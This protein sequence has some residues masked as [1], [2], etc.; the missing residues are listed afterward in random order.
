MRTVHTTEYRAFLGKL[1]AAREQRGL[2]QRDVAAAL[3]IPQSQVSR[4]ES[5]ERSVNAVDGAYQLQ[6]VNGAPLPYT[7]NLGF[8][9]TSGLLVLSPK[10]DWSFATGGTAAGIINGTWHAEGNTVTLLSYNPPTVIAATH[11]SGAL[12]Y[13]DGGLTYQFVRQ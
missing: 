7:T 8:S 6:T 13:T 5:G 2:S 10:G 12:S 9:I 11:T 3:G 1:I 4:M